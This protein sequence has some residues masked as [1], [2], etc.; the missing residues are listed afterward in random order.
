[1]DSELIQFQMEA[2][3]GPDSQPF[4]TFIS[5]HWPS[6][7]EKRPKAE[8][9]FNMMKQKDPESIALKLVDYLGPS[10]DIYYRE[11]C[12]GLL[13]NLSVS[14]QAII[15]SMIVDRISLEE[16]GFIIQELLIT[17]WTLIDS[18]PADKTWPELLPPLYSH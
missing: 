6:S 13:H 11:R 1:M 2:I 3:L 10:H 12:A 18:V 8:W 16:P 9:M 17:V 5:N 4:Q 7:E 14:A 15:K